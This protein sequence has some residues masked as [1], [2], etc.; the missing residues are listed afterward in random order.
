MK[1][2]KRWLLAAAAASLMVTMSAPA[3]AQMRVPALRQSLLQFE[4]NVNWSAVSRAFVGQRPGWLAAVNAATTPQQI[5]AQALA[6]ETQMGWDA[7]QDSW[8]Q[9][10][11]GWVAQCNSATT[12]GQVA[13]ILLALENTTRWSAVS[14][15][16]R[17]VRPGWVAQLQS[18][19]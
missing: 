3:H 5:A 8:H 9:Q 2:V 18:I 14:Q 4:A 19:H 17:A 13:A 11:P 16:W 1:N 10:R 6:L 12:D 15:N 7:V